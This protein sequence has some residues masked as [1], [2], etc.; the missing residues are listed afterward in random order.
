MEIKYT[1]TEVKAV[2]KRS[3]GKRK[4]K[5]LGFRIDPTCSSFAGKQN[6]YSPISNPKLP[7]C[8]LT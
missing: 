5:D 2:V 4:S 6:K 1:E 8:L 7:W 3:F